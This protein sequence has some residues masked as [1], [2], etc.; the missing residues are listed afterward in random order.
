M[1]SMGGAR[2]AGRG[3]GMRRRPGEGPMRARCLRS[4]AVAHGQTGNPG[5]VT[6][7]LKYFRQIE[8][9][10]NFRPIFSLSERDSQLSLRLFHV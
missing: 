5:I 4:P 1:R 9:L 8:F 6:G 7:N 3:R 2:Q 10:G